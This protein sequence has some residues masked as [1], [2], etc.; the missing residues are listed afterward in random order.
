M[1]D[2][3]LLASDAERDAAAE[4]LR[5]AGAEGRLTADELDERLG[6]AFGART[7]GELDALVADLPASRRHQRASTRSRRPELAVFV[8]VSLLL[9]G[10]WALSGMGYFWP[11]WPILGWGFFL[12]VPGGPFGACSPRRRRGRAHA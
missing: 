2:L 8:P 5:Q 1:S 7:R 12:L 9:I 10:I 4:R 3:T 6:R 11:A